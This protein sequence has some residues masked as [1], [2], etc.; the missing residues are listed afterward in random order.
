MYCIYVGGARI[1]FIFTEVHTMR[2]CSTRH[3][4]TEYNMKPS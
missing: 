1:S 2:V 4:Y 3:V